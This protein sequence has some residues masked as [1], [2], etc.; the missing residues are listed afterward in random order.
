MGHICFK[1]F[2]KKLDICQISKKSFYIPIAI[3]CDNLK[4]LP[5]SCTSNTGNWPVGIVDLRAGHCS[6]SILTS[7]YC[8]PAAANTKRAISLWK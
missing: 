5:L 3:D 8:W 6:L 4:T 2:L 1:K 7:S